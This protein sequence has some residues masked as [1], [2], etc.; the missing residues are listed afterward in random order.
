MVALGA[1]D[2]SSVIRRLKLTILYPLSTTVLK[3]LKR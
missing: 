2:W 1:L 3:A